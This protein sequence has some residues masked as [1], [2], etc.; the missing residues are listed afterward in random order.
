[1]HFNPGTVMILS[2]LIAAVI[3][4]VQERGFA[5]VVA[6]L[7]VGLQA[8]MAFGIVSLNV[9]GLPIPLILA[10]VLTVAGAIAWTRAGNKA[11][12]SA[13]TVVT[14]VGGYELALA[15]NLLR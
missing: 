4:V 15:L 1:M 9:R 10:S 8:L 12:I 3:L 6:L 7:A 11:A 2:A 13:A 5:A 14:L